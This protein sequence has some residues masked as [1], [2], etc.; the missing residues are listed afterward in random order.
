M[1]A[2]ETVNSSLRDVLHVVFKRKA[3]IFAFFVATVIVVS[4]GTFLFPP[5]YE[6]TAELLVKIGRENLYVPATGN[7]GPLLSVDRENQINSEL[8]ILKSR[9]LTEKVAASLGA[10]NIFP[11]LEFKAGVAHGSIQALDVGQG[12]IKEAALRIQKGLNIERVTKSDVIEVGYRHEDPEMAARVVNTL[13]QFF[14]DLHVNVH[15][16]PQSH[17]FFKMQS[18]TSRDKLK[19]L[20]EQLKAFKDEH[21]VTSLKEEQVLLLKQE[22]EFVVE[23]NR[24]ITLEAETKNRIKEIRKQLAATPETI[25]QGKEIDHNPYV[26]NTLEAR[27]VELELK[28]KDLLA[29]YTEQNRL[30]KNV[31]NEI[32]IVRKKLE[33]LDKKAYGKSMYGPNLTYQRLKEDLLQNEAN[34]KGLAAKLDS[35]RAQLKECKRKLARLNQIELQLNQLQG[36]VEL[37]TQNYRLY[38]TKL[39]ESRISKAMD[40]EKIANVR[41]IEPALPPLRP[42]SPKV[43]LNIALCVLLGSFGGLFL[44]FFLEYLDDS[45]DRPEDVERYLNLPVLTSV[46]ELKNK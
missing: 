20:E 12:L 1:D 16:N 37:E 23:L 6:S 13:V 17:E 46:P 31:R 38:S 3:Q 22:A 33:G 41:V 36:Q 25:P 11:R 14:L 7:V 29:K 35:Q 21:N 10:R 9:S 26:I 43:W 15:E 24:S 27:L 44:G 32:Q 5:K 18:Q 8:E 2:E 19:E 4:V 45:L 39:E 42:V 30:V 28:E 40:A 34:L